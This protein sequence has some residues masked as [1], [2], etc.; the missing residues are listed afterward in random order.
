[1]GRASTARRDTRELV[2]QTQRAPALIEHTQTTAEGTMIAGPAGGG[3][4][5]ASAQAIERAAAQDA[6]AVGKENGQAIIEYCNAAAKYVR[7]QA[8]QVR[9]LADSY[10]TEAEALAASLENIGQLEAQRTVNF[11]ARIRG[12]VN[13]L[14]QVRADFNVETR[15]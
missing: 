4:S 15:Q 7:E 3:M 11:T 10:I 2:Q 6:P 14:E 9:A 13:K 8:Q 5:D 12:A 1:M